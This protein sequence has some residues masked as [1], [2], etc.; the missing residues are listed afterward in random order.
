[1][2]VKNKKNGTNVLAFREGIQNV[3]VIITA[4][5]VVNIPALTE[6][7]QIINKSDFEDNR[8]WFEI[9]A[10]EIKKEVV[11]ENKIKKEE[12]V[13]EAKKEISEEETSLEKAKKE[14]KEYTSSKKN[15]E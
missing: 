2:I 3:R 8:G 15:K 4:G 14:V 6:F 7:E 12:K 10:E 5:E 9:I 13:L 11:I 1:M